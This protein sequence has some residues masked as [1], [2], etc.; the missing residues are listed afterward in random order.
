MQ[1]LID[2]SDPNEIR[3][4]VSW[5]IMD[6][7]TTNPSLVAKGGP[8]PLDTITRVLKASSGMVFCQVI[9]WKDTGPIKSQARWLHQLSDRIIVKIPMSIAGIQAV[10]ELK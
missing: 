1:L 7:V 5:G 10:T 9:G 6:G 8:D 2:S 4:A 3:T